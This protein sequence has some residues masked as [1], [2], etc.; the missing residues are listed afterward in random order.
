MIKKVMFHIYSLSK[1]GAERVVTTLAG[2][3]ARRGLDV[4][5]AT[6]T[7]GEKEYPLPE[8]VRR[9]DVGLSEEEEKMGRIGRVRRRIG[10]LRDCLKKERPDVVFA[11]MQTANYRAVTAARPLKIPVIISVRSDPS[12]DYAGKMQK[13]LS[14][15]L[16][17]RAAGA[18]FQTTQARDFFPPQVAEKAAV[19]LN[20]LNPRCMADH[21][22]IKERRKVF[23][24][25]GRHHE[26]KDYMT[27]AKAFGH[28]HKD[29]PDYTL[30]IYGGDSGD[31]TR[32]CI[33]EY[34]HA[35]GLDEAILFMGDREDVDR[36][37]TDAAAYVLSSKY[38]G[39]PNALM[40]AMALGLPVIATDCPCGGPAALIRDGENG[41]LVE[42]KNPKELAAAMTKMAE[43]PEDAERC[44][45]EAAKIR[46]L[47]S[48][49][50]VT[51][52][53]LAYAE[54]RIN[55]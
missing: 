12:V 16:Y 28:F 18:V 24:S 34:V 31:N 50:R 55:G 2:E 37:I 9:L 42:V 45:R 36:C 47:A 21:G 35:H 54:K 41:L 30:E 7:R 32:L 39:M 13:K 26:A 44:G 23:V 17:K 1:G 3:M 33:K 19:L 48:T 22:E 53:W 4:S 52:E 27:L 38:E 15:Y 29:H 8:G 43:S 6:L 20:P 14:A 11:F 51:D 49:E 10:H 40:E 5:I 46:E 25:V